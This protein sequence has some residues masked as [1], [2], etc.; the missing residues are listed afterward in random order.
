M[1]KINKDIVVYSQ[2][3]KN[4]LYKR[5]VD[6]LHLTFKQVETD[7]ISKGAKGI[8][9]SSLSRYF[10][11]ERPIHGSLKHSNIIWLCLRYGI[12]VRLDIR[13][14][15]YDEKVCVETLKRFFNINQNEEK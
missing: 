14:V 15:P 6:E 7:A 10:S 1:D 3:L 5:I 13:P 8:F 4:A 12:N 2:T 9:S 11:Q